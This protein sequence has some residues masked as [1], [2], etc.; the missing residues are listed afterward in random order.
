MDQTVYSNI[1]RYTYDPYYT[2][3]PYYGGWA[4]G[5]LDPYRRCGGYG[6]YGAFA[7]PPW[8]GLNS[9]EGFG[10]VYRPWAGRS[11]LVAPAIYRAGSGPVGSTPWGSGRQVNATRPIGG[12]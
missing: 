11:L 6:G 8:R 9:Y 5:T 10:K 1:P 2:D 3:N 12:R 4:Y 7:I